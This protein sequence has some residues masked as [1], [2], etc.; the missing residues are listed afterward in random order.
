MKS[1]LTTGFWGTRDRNAFIRA[2]QTGINQLAIGGV[3]AGDNMF[4]FGRNLSF[5]DDPAFMAA[6]ARAGLDEVEQAIL[7][8]THLLCWAAHNGLR[9]KG[10]FVE[11]GCYKGT[12][13]RIVCDYVDFGATGR[14]FY[15]YDAFEH[16]DGMPN[17]A[18]PHH[19]PDLYRRTVE[20]FAD[21]PGV[22]VIQGLVPDSFAKGEP[23]RIA[24]LHI[25]MNNAAAELAAL[26]RLFDRVVDGGLVVLDDY[27]GIV[28][29]AQKVAE[30]AFFAA[31]GY[32]VV[33]LPTGQGL[34]LK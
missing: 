13:A 10:D 29:R 19:G 31:R 11:C 28:F 30:D 17:P 15:L 7:W 22:R 26:D 27:G 6:V 4:T 14:Q 8:R 1:H 18:L 21:L 2:I 33:E 16:R 5:L 3:Y 25:D 34:V 32:K 24:F 9:R 20:R 12:S 23:D